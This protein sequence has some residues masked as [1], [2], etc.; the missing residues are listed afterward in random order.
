MQQN[1]EVTVDYDDMKTET[2]KAYLFQIDGSNIWLPK[3]QVIDLDLQQQY[4]TIP[5]WLASEKGLN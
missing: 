3:S 4:V 2:A 1:E 5:E